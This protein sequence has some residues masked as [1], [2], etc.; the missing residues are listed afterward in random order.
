MDIYGSNPIPLIGK[1]LHGQAAEE[2][3]EKLQNRIG[4]LDKDGYRM[5]EWYKSFDKL[6]KE[7]KD[8]FYEVKTIVE[9][10]NPGKYFRA[11]IWSWRP[12]HMLCETVISMSNLDIDTEGWG[13][14]SGYGI[15]EQTECDELAAAIQVFLDQFQ[16]AFKLH[17]DK[18]EHDLVLYVNMQVVTNDFSQPFG[19]CYSDKHQFVKRED[20]TPEVAENYKKFLRGQGISHNLQKTEFTINGRAVCSAYGCHYDHLQEFVVFLRHCGGFQ[21]H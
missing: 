18:D 4:P 2:A 20:W 19:V 17:P 12:M 14:N 11:N 15:E 5:G 3:F 10:Y 1:E 21:I 9:K 13:E 7:E 6:S 16:T 8:A